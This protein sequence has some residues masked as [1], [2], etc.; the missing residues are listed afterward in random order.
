[1]G[2]AAVP[3]LLLMLPRLNLDL[4]HVRRNS[5]AV[6]SYVTPADIAWL[7][8]EG[9]QFELSPPDVRRLACTLRAC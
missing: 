1:V 6:K 3:V 8:H 5:T 2:V 7:Q 4:R 9:F